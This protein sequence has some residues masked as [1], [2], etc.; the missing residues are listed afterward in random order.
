MQVV[1]DT[2]LKIRLIILIILQQR[3]QIIIAILRKE[4]SH[5]KYFIKW[6]SW[7]LVNF[8]PYAVT[9]HNVA[10]FTGSS[11]KIRG[12]IQNT[13]NNTWNKNDWNISVMGIFDKISVYSSKMG[14][15]LHVVH[16]GL[17]WRRQKTSGKLSKT[18][19]EQWSFICKT[20][21]P[22][23]CVLQNL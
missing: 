11:N 18:L 10:W 22:N 14:A 5:L 15:S 2:V 4:G 12:R 1:N 19:R 17:T 3:T 6:P 13:S 9:S 16:E 8:Y 20:T 7:N 21:H 23:M